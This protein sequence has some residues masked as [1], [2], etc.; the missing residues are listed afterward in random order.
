MGK[1]YKIH[2]LSFFFVFAFSVSAKAEGTLE[3]EPT[4]QNGYTTKFQV[5]SDRVSNIA[6]FSSPA[7]KRL[8]IHIKDPANEKIYLGFG[9]MFDADDKTDMGTL[10]CSFRVKDAT[11]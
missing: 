11:G 9:A 2:L 8:Y 1:Y 7:D 3:L 5:G 6:T 4:T 10:N